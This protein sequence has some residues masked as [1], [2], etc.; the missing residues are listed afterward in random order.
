MNWNAQLFEYLTLL[1][2]E[3]DGIKVRPCSGSV[4][5]TTSRFIYK[6]TPEKCKDRLLVAAAK[7]EESIF[8]TKNATPHGLC[9][10]RY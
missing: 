9:S 3:A 5:L 1:V 8:M 7:L 10:R 2:V 4:K 6:D